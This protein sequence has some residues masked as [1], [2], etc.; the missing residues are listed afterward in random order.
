MALYK[1]TGNHPDNAPAEIAGTPIN[2]IIINACPKYPTGAQIPMVAD[3]TDYQEYL[4][5]VAAG[6]TAD[7]AD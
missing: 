2:R 3:N 4:E 5:W 1:L 6:N 7:A